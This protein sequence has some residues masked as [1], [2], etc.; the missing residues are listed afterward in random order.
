[1]ERGALA[2]V[3][4]P[5]DTRN[6]ANDPQKEGFM[7][8]RKEALRVGPPSNPPIFR[9]HTAFFSVDELVKLPLCFMNTIHNAGDRSNGG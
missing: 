4:A 1:M 7:R 9:Y 2:Q 3:E 6:S 5:L 8:R